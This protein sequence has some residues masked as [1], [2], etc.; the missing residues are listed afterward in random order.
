MS[1]FNFLYRYVFKYNLFFHL[2]LPLLLF[3]SPASF[4]LLYALFWFDPLFV[5]V[6]LFV[7]LFVL[8]CF[9]R[10]RRITTGHSLPR[11]PCSASSTRA[12]WAS[13]VWPAPTAA[14]Q[15]P[16]GAYQAHQHDAVSFFRTKSAETNAVFFFLHEPRRL[17]KMVAVCLFV[18]LFVFFLSKKQIY[19]HKP[20]PTFFYCSF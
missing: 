12:S 3:S 13:G 14:A 8:F 11:L 10:N 2:W 7:C 4:S 17:A 20:N 5:C 16:I 18:C 6:C 1:F 19:I 9:S 15:S